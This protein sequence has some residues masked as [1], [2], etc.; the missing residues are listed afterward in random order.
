MAAADSTDSAAA[1]QQPD[2][3]VVVNGSSG[4]EYAKLLKGF[5]QPP[6]SS[7]EDYKTV[8]DAAASPITSGG[9]IMQVSDS[10]S[11]DGSMGRSRNKTKKACVL[12]LSLLLLL[13][14]VLL[15]FARRGRYFSK[16]HSY[17]A[18]QYRYD[19]C[20][21]LDENPDP[22]FDNI[23]YPREISS[24]EKA[25]MCKSDEGDLTVE[26][27]L[28]F[29]PNLDPTVGVGLF[30]GECWKDVCV[31]RVARKWCVGPDDGEYHVDNDVA[32]QHPP[33]MCMLMDNHHDVDDGDGG[34]EQQQQQLV[35][36]RTY[37]E[38][39]TGHPGQDCFS[40]DWLLPYTDCFWGYDDFHPPDDYSEYEDKECT[41]GVIDDVSEICSKINQS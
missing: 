15:S 8:P 36:N 16:Y 35:V 23:T 7:S 38:T 39:M 26:V 32:R 2:L 14:T 28:G 21:I 5:H 20:L 25:T 10:S 13:L 31:V 34:H 1:T 6:P 9:S 24:I 37:F 19:G 17:Y 4:M 11:S 3:P 18:D 33:A 41:A 30:P 12:L 27:E 29:V 22:R 40:F